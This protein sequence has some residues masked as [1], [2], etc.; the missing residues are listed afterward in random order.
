MLNFKNCIFLFT[1][2]LIIYRTQNAQADDLNS[3]AELGVNGNVTDGTNTKNI[4]NLLNS[5]Y[6]LNA[7]PS[8]NN[9]ALDVFNTEIINNISTPFY[10]NSFV[11]IP[12]HVLSS[13]ENISLSNATN[14]T[15]NALVS[16]LLNNSNELFNASGKLN[17]TYPLPVQQSAAI[18][19]DGN[20]NGTL[21]KTTA[22][23]TPQEVLNRNNDHQVLQFANTANTADKQQISIIGSDTNATI[24]KVQNGLSISASSSFQ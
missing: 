12:T 5:S 18:F 21:F 8:L 10:N 20:K 14:N 19:S 1:T 24:T 11:N 2:I 13:L 6:P 16:P 7:E 3:G 23:L 22:F 15:E 17:I 4:I 9:T